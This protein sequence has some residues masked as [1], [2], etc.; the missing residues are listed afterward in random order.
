MQLAPRD[1]GLKRQEAGLRP[2]FVVIPMME[3][4]MRLMCH[5][6]RHHRPN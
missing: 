5:N 4:A 3:I 6:I 2:R 1:Q